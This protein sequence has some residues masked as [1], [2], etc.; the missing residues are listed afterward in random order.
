MQSL[1]AYEQSKKANFLLAQDLIH[2]A[3]AP[4]LNSMQVQDRVKLQG[5][6]KLGLQQLVDDFSIE[7][8]KDDF[9]QPNE[10]KLAVSQA[11]SYFL[12]KN[13]QD[14]NHLIL[15]TAKEADKVF[16]IYYMLLNLYLALAEM[17]DR[18]IAHTGKSRLSANKLVK[19]FAIS[20]ELHNMTLRQTFRWDEEMDFVKSLYNQVLKKNPKYLEYCEKLN[21]TLEEDTA[22]LKYLVK[23]VFL[24]NEVSAN[25]F[26]GQYL[27]WSEDKETLR[28]M[29][30]HSFQNY[31]ENNQLTI[32]Q[33]DE[34]WQERKDFLMVLFKNGVKEEE[35]LMRTILPSLKNWEYDRIAETDKILLKIAL[36]EMKEFPG[37]PIKVTINE[38]IEIAKTYSTPKSGQFVN[39]VLDRLSK[40]LVAKGDIKKSGRGMLDNK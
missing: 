22:L 20:P 35:E 19:E 30:A 36:I 17:S 6:T 7:G 24:K 29:V 28:A 26:E 15:R 25:F 37:I 18:D 34:T 16:E 40:E 1:Y 31:A 8:D 5:L 10:V 33:P 12:E 2:E 9:E 21:H 27:Y 4:D 39:G 3:F 23:N 38:I 14:F 13:K 11:S 32:A